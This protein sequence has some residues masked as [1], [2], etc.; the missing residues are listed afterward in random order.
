MLGRS[1]PLENGGEHVFELVVVD[2]PKVRAIGVLEDRV[3]DFGADF[4]GDHL[5]GAFFHA[6]NGLM[7]EI[8][9]VGFVLGIGACGDGRRNSD[10]ARA[11]GGSDAGGFVEYGAGGGDGHG[12]YAGDCVGGDGELVHPVAGVARV[13]CLAED[14]VDTGDERGGGRVVVLVAVVGGKGKLRDAGAN[15]L[16]GGRTCG[17]ARIR[18]G[19]AG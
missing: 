1:A 4:R 14:V 6:N 12:S 16:M 7:D 8:Q 18:H 3:G 9:S 15:V 2:A 10:S 11:G 13:V 19:W 17:E 5:G